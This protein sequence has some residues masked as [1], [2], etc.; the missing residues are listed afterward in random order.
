MHGRI[1]GFPNAEEWWLLVEKQGI[2]LGR[3]DCSYVPKLLIKIQP[4]LDFIGNSEFVD[5]DFCL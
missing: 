4:K 5:T 3:R 1:L 2:L